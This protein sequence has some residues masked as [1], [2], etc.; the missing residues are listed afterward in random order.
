[1]SDKEPV[2]QSET[3]VEEDDE[4]D[5]WY[6]FRCWFNRARLLTASAGTNG[7][8]ALDVPVRRRKWPRYHQSADS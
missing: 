3:E 6:G 2:Q 8:L 4:P 7:S 1:M 5:E